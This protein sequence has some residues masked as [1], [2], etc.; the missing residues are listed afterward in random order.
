[1]PALFITGVS[2]YLGSELA[3]LAAPDWSVSGSVLSSGAPAGVRAHRLDVRDA[4]A[5]RAALATERPDAVVH[6]AYRQSGEGAEAITANGAETVARAARAAGA[7]LV[8]LS[9]DLVFSGRAGRPLREDDP[10][11]PLPGYGRWKAQAEGMVSAAHPDALLVRTSL[12]YGGAELSR[13][14]Q[15]A[16]DATRN[17]ELTLFDDELRCPVAAGD[18]ARALLQLTSTELSGPLHVAGA[19]A[20][21]RLEFGRLIAGRHGRDPDSIRGAPGGP[22]R[23]KDCRLDSSRA[24]ALLATRLR[25]AREVLG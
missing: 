6:T 22:E 15:L 7:R 20:V 18:L 4:T 14:E 9:S 21:S 19:D 1:M 12:I 16:L 11:D 23:P 10:P 8:H 2:G 25:G 3:R 17:P 24:Q 5:L 13:H